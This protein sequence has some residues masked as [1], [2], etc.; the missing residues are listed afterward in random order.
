VAAVL[1]RK[2][3]ISGRLVVVV[4]GRNIAPDRYAQIL[5]D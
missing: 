3:D 2:V 4:T 5:Q 1:G